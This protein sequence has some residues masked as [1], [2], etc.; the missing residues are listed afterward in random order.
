MVV[1]CSSDDVYGETA[2]A[3]HKAL[4]GISIV[5]IAG[6]PADSIEEL[7]KAGLEHFIHRN[8]NV[9]KP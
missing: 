6:Y 8:S 4:S 5:V 9:L 1:L 2:P 7:K 3:A